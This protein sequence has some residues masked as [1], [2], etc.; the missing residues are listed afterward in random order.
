MLV[1]FQAFILCC[2]ATHILHALRF[3]SDSVVLVVTKVI[4]AA[5]SCLTSAML[6]WVVPV[7][8]SM[9]ARLHRLESELGDM[10]REANRRQYGMHD[11]ARRP[12]RELTARLRHEQIA[13]SP[14][15]DRASSGATLA[16]VHGGSNSS[17]TAPLVQDHHVDSE[18][19]YK[20]LPLE[21][22]CH[23]AVRAIAQSVPGFASVLMFMELAHDP[24]AAAP[25]PAELVTS[26]PGAGDDVVQ[27]D[28]T[29]SGLRCIAEYHPAAPNSSA[30]LFADHIVDTHDRIYC[31]M[32]P[33]RASRF[34][35]V[36]LACLIGCTRFVN[37]IAM[38][39]NY[40]S[41]RGL[42]VLCATK[43]GPVISSVNEILHYED[44]LHYIQTALDLAHARDRTRRLRHELSAANSA[45]TA[46]EAARTSALEQVVATNDLLATT[47]H[48][49]RTPMNAI[50]GMVDVLLDESSNVPLCHEVR[51][52]L[53]IVLSSA[54]LLGN[55]INNLLDLAKLHH[56]G[57]AGE[58]L[59]LAHAPF[60]L[61]TCIEACLDLVAPR[62]EHIDVAL[63]YI[64]DADVPEVVAGDRTRVTQILANLLGNAAKFTEQGEILV[65]VSTRPRRVV[66]PA[67][68]TSVRKLD[69]RNPALGVTPATLVAVSPDS[70]DRAGRPVESATP[71]DW[72]RKASLSPGSRKREATSASSAS[73]PDQ[74]S[75]RAASQARTRTNSLGGHAGYLYFYVVD[76]GC[77]IHQHDMGRLFERFQQGQSGA[78]RRQHGTGLGLAVSARLVE[79]HAGQMAVQSAPGAGTVFS[80][81]LRMQYAGGAH[82][83]DHDDVVQAAAV[84]WEPLWQAPAAP[85]GSPWAGLELVVVPDPK[86]ASSAR[87]L[88]SLLDAIGCAYTC[89]PTVAQAQ[90]VARR[91]HAAHVE[92][93]HVAFLVVERALIAPA[94]APGTATDGT[95]GRRQEL[96]AE[97]LALQAI[98]PIALLTRRGRGDELTV[99]MTWFD[100]VLRKPMRDA[101]AM[102]AT[103]VAAP[104]PTVVPAQVAVA[105]PVAVR[106]PDASSPAIAAAA[107]AAAAAAFPGIQRHDSVMLHTVLDRPFVADFPSRGSPAA[108]TPPAVLPPLIEPMATPSPAP[109]TPTSTA[110]TTRT[111]ATPERED[112]MRQAVLVVDDNVINL[113]VAQKL[114]KSIG[115]TA[116][117]TANHGG[118]AVELVER[119][120]FDV[121]FM[122]VS[123]P[124]MD[125]LEA[126]RRIRHARSTQAAATVSP[127]IC[128]MTAS[129]LPD[130]QTACQE[131]GMDDFVP[132]PVKRDAVIR[133]LKN[134]H[135]HLQHRDRGS[136][137]P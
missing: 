121:V 113:K 83:G 116:I 118:E 102:P 25:A 1:L 99:D 52:S 107:A 100:Y 78:A 117:T 76:T 112:W 65:I 71:A 66:D 110:T 62:L 111:I 6:F 21:R 63:N 104:L 82:A 122:D 68:F 13:E 69:F 127:W 84:A 18:D 75:S 48:E 73:A 29:A 88:S 55:L 85:P 12:L 81:S 137:A 74:L 50:V 125:G 129:A 9:P 41:R 70:I 46:A 124:V 36:D 105:V 135:D 114:L 43:E 40:G 15:V 131:A 95:R 11:G 2:G 51:E 42:L 10:I 58:A 39:M 57:T 108:A 94:T 33:G 79:L 5:V 126:T 26:G 7:A 30:R 96:R 53:E 8:F 115:V 27:P 64:L 54:N 130:E 23:L 123:M 19:E 106:A 87:S 119:G 22:V 92:P 61:R 86:L 34:S 59:V 134:A 133:A 38:Q 44:P 14:G 132:K 56:Q 3:S 45:R 77:G 136:D 90:R 67:V 17:S 20:A 32:A 80:F 16:A 60:R 120:A 103:D 128:A 72:D 31:S 89:V 28:W 97:L 4:T 101:P 109:S 91:L 93:I 49:L 98:G 47:S 37:A 35:G 24:V